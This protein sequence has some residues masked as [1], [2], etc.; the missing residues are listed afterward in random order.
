MALL[1]NCRVLGL[2]GQEL[3]TRESNRMVFSQWIVLTEDSP[4]AP[5]RGIC[6][7][8]VGLCRGQ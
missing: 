7:E 1:L 3:A 6:V 2:S 4:E 5:V 8:D